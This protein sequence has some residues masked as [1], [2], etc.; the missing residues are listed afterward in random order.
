MQQSYHNKMLEKKLKRV[1]NAGDI[2][3]EWTTPELEYKNIERLFG[4]KNGFKIDLFT[5]GKNNSKCDHFLTAKDNAIR[6]D[7]RLHCQNNGIGL[8]GFANPPY[9]K[10]HKG[11]N[12]D[13]TT[14]TG[15]KSMMN[16]AFIEMNLGFYSVWLLPCAPEADWFPHE[17]A[18]AIY[19]VT[20]GR[21]TFESPHWYKQDPMGS[22]PTCGR[23]GSIII[24]FDPND[25]SIGPHIGFVSRDELRKPLEEPDEKE[26]TR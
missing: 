19:F 22:K 17:K 1:H 26:K 10:A 8:A 18:T 9:S 6:I 16:K 4:P 20:G 11:L 15:L 7:W 24:V 25:D 21:L 23:C 14:C 12:E 2:G 13:G 5:D 3:D